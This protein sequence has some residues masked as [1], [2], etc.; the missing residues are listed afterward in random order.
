MLTGE[1][2]GNSSTLLHAR[3]TGWPANASLRVFAVPS[4]A[5][6]H[7]RGTK[8]ESRYGC[9]SLPLCQK[10]QVQNRPSDIIPLESGGSWLGD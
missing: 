5:L 7:A 8:L 9:K 10:T 4:S 1:L 2:T 6:Q 3:A